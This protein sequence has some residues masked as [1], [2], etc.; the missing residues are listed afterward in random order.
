M[1]ALSQSFS[2]IFL[3][4][5]PDCSS[6]LSSLRNG[7]TSMTDLFFGRTTLEMRRAIGQTVPVLLAIF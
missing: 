4:L 6:S 7:L 5:S 1:F 2:N 3:T